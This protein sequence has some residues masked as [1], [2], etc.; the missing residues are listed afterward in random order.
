MDDIKLKSWKIRN[1]QLYKKYTF[2]SYMS[3]ISFVNK[4]AKYAE[5]VNHHPGVR[6][7]YG[8]VEVYLTTHDA[9]NIPKKDVTSVHD[10]NKITKK[11]VTSAKKYDEYYNE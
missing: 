3:G 8:N 10:L 2:D 6:I 1:G 7:G 4:I 5:R 11:D 9:S